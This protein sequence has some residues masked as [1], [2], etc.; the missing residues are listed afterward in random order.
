MF[1]LDFRYSI[2]RSLACGCAL[3][4][5]VGWQHHVDTLLLTSLL[6]YRNWHLTSSRVTTH[7]DRLPSPRSTFGMGLPLFSSPCCPIVDGAFTIAVKLRDSQQLRNTDEP[8][9]VST[10]PGKGQVNTS[11]IH[12]SK[13][14]GHSSRY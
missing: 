7:H 3:R 9:G 13:E 6:A 2:E 14:R 10:A 11:D 5:I 1:G 12:Q 8:A 4:T